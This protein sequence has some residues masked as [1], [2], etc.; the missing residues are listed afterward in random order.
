M[1]RAARGRP[2]DRVELAKLCSRVE[3]D[4]VGARDR[5]ARPA[6]RR[7]AARRAARCGST[8]AP[9]IEPVPLELGGWR[10]VTLDSGAAHE[11]AGGGYNERRAECRAACEAL[12]IA[13][14]R[15][16]TS[17][18]GLPE[19]L[20]RRVRH[21]I[22]ENERVDATAGGARR[23]RPA[24]VGRAARRLAREPA[25]PLRGLR[26]RG[27]A[28]GRAAKR[29]GAAGARMVGGGFGGSVLALLRPARRRRTA[30]SQWPPGPP[31]A[32]SD[33]SSSCPSG[34]ASAQPT[35]IAPTTS[36][37]SPVPEVDVDPG[38]LVDRPASDAPSPSTSRI[39]P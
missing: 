24:E 5:A 36:I 17:A 21:V 32:G 10:L 6:R 14:L 12:G 16:A 22:S 1:P 33:S 30:P 8:S 31:P 34:R 19:P 37:P 11:H 35:K 18:D 9:P 13:S 39:A 7:C 4:W 2:R 15:D 27:R 23:R 26:A 25:R 3:N 20:D 29:A 28:H 38:R